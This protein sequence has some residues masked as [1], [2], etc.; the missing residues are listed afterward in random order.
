MAKLER[1]YNVPLRKE[2]LKAP[3]Y[4]RAKRAVT[5][6]RDFLKKHMKS[7]NVKLGRQLNHAVWKRSI[8]HPPHHVKVTA[9]KYDDGLVRAELH[10]FPIEEPKTEEKK[11]ALKTL[12]EKVM[13]KK[14]E[15][16]EQVKEE[17]KPKEAKTEAKVTEL[18][19]TE[20]KKESKPNK[21]EHNKQ[22]LGTKEQ[23]K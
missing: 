14:E 15:K 11:G 12:K 5:A 13:G 20:P 22:E 19:K 1:V 9:I 23:N 6:L 21:T 7:E 3:H 10:G 2:W 4:K 17:A 8:K 18:K 16:P